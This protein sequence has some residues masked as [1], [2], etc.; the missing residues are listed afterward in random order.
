M[1]MLFAVNLGLMPML[2]AVN[3][4]LL[5]LL[6]AINLATSSLNSLQVQSIWA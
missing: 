4:G 6:F 1:P 2:F 3:V 5:P